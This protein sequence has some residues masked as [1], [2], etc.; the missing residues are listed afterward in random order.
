MLIDRGHLRQDA[1]RW[2]LT[3]EGEL[4]VP[5]SVQGLIAARLDDLPGR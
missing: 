5:E 2:R 3:A 4:P 1:G